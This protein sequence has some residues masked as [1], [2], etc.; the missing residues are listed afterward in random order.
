[1]IDVLGYVATTFVVISMC[2]KNINYLR[3]F[4]AI[5]CILWIWYG[6]KINN[7]PTMLV[8]AIILAVHIIWWIK[9]TKQN[10]N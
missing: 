5:A 6:Y 10:E 8:N 9:N 7:N 2:F 3:F 1:M 4:N